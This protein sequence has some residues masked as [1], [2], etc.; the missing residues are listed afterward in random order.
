MRFLSW[1]W[2]FFFVH[3]WRCCRRTE[4]PPPRQQMKPINRS[5]RWLR[6]PCNSISKL[7][8]KKKTNEII[9]RIRN[10]SNGLNVVAVVVAVA[11]VRRRET[12]PAGRLGV[13]GVGGVEGQRKTERHE[14]CAIT[15][16]NGPMG[17]RRPELI[18]QMASPPIE[19]LDTISASSYDNKRLAGKNP[20]KTQC[21]CVCVCVCVDGWAVKRAVMK[22][23]R[24]VV[25]ERGWKCSTRSA[26][27]NKR[28]I[29]IISRPREVAFISTT[30]P[31]ER[32]VCPDPGQLRR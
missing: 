10:E 18:P 3:R 20:V 13:G 28:P 15:G 27:E 8:L 5:C 16:P 1:K 12:N 31:A 4:P 17:L 21:V 6:L 29:K 2:L 24:V 9:K 11:E 14:W 23:N 30:S 22:G 7:F 32:K 25:D 26:K 19:T